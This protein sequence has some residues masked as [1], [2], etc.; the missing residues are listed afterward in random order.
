MNGLRAKPL[1]F[2]L[3]NLNRR[4]R[5]ITGMPR[6]GVGPKT[7]GKNLIMESWDGWL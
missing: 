3:S 4:R 5:N 1:L 2:P 6:E 7:Y